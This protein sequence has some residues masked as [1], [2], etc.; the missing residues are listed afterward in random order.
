MK[1]NESSSILLYVKFCFCPDEVFAD[2][3]FRRFLHLLARQRIQNAQQQ[4]QQL[5]NN[6]NDLDQLD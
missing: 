5:Q 1:H 6:S 2:D 3:D 4:Q